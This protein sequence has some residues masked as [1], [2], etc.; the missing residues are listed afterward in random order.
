M[1]LQLRSSIIYQY[2]LRPI[3]HTHT[4]L[5]YD[6]LAGYSIGMPTLVIVL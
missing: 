1:F 3:V 5:R 6:I 4:T 2:L